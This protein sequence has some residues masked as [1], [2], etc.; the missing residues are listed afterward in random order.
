[1]SVKS[2]YYR[3][4][5]FKKRSTFA[6]VMIKS[7][8][9]CFLRHSVVLY[10]LVKLQWNVFIVSNDDMLMLCPNVSQKSTGNY[11]CLFVILS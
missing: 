11:L 2:H 10:C 7:Q 9:H 4:K 5:E 1:M 6:R 8:V 3:V